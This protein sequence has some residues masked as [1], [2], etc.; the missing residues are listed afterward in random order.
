MAE[1]SGGHD[2][3]AAITRQLESF[4]DIV[5]GFSLAQTALNFVMPQHAITFITQPLGIGAFLVTFVVVAQFW[6]VHST[7]FRNYFTPNKPMVALNFIALAAVVLQVYSLQLVLHFIQPGMSATDGGVAARI[8]AGIFAITFGALALLSGLG[9]FYKWERLDDALR[10]S[11]VARTIK[12][13]CTV[14]GAAVGTVYASNH[15]ASLTVR[16]EQH[17]NVR[18]LALPDQIIVGLALG[19]VIGSILAAVVVRKM[20]PAIPLPG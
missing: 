7:I 18:M 11:G 16:V 2:N 14:I 1:S 3:Q 13:G 8:Y 4:S 9:T 19:F 6:S 10:A 17:E 12:L 15:L 20:R 5:I